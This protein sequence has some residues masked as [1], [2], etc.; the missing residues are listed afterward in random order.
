MTFYNHLQA[1]FEERQDMT[2]LKLKFIYAS[3][4]GLDNAIDFFEM[5]KVQMHNAREKMENILYTQLKKF[6]QSKYL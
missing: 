6:V 4:A 5:N 2:R 3:T 1:Y